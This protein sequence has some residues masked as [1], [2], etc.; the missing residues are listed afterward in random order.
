MKIFILLFLKRL[1]KIY[2]GLRLV[3]VLLLCVEFGLWVDFG[4]V[5]IYRVGFVNVYDELLMVN[6]FLLLNI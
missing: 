4:W 6:I 1:K 3:R 5:F 2:N